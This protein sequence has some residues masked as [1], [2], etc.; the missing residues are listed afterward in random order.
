VCNEFESTSC[1]DGWLA[2]IAYATRANYSARD[3]EKVERKLI[4]SFDFDKR[5]SP[6]SMNTILTHLQVQFIAH[7]VPTCP[8]VGPIRIPSFVDRS[9]IERVPQF[10]QEFV[11]AHQI[12]GKW[13]RKLGFQTNPLFGAKAEK[14]L[15]TSHLPP[16]LQ[17]DD[18]EYRLLDFGIRVDTL[19]DDHCREVE[20][21]VMPG[22]DPLE[23]DDCDL[24]S[25][26]PAFCWE[27]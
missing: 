27:D 23:G 5:L 14:P 15:T 2:R 13:Y 20:Q 26:L 1:D 3:L 17:L 11:R 10:A 16:Y 22:S 8:P 9:P 25:V 4:S 7:D 18:Q 19:R 24:P 12:Q 21:F 6:V